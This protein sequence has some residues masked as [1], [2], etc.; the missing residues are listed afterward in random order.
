MVEVLLIDAET[1]RRTGQI[2]L[3]CQPSLDVIWQLTRIDGARRAAA[4]EVRLH[5]CYD[6]APA[7][8]GRPALLN[9]Y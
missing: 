3:G 9:I 8:H 5:G 6:T 7:L 2:L 4:A 1:R